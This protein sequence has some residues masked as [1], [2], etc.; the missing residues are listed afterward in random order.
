ME[1]LCWDEFAGAGEGR[2]RKEAEVGHVANEH[3]EWLDV[4]GLKADAHWTGGMLITSAKMRQ[5]HKTITKLGQLKSTVLIQGESGTGKELVAEA[6]HKL[7]PFST[8][9]FVVFN[10]SNLVD[11]LA[12][13]QLFGHVKGSFTDAR[14]DALGYFRSAEGGTLFLDEIGDLPLALQP[15]LLRAVETHEIQPVG[16]S[17]SY[18]VDFRLVVATNRDVRAM[19]AEGRFRD[20]LYYRLNAA[21]IMVPPLR[22]RREAIGA[23]IAHFIELYSGESG[24]EVKYISRRAL[25]LLMSY[26]WPGNLRELHHVIENVVVM[27]EGDR[28]DAGL[29]PSYIGAPGAKACGLDA[30]APGAQLWDQPGSAGNGDIVPA[31]H[32]LDDAIKTALVRALREAKGNCLVAAKLLGVSRYTVYRMMARYSVGQARDFRDESDE[33]RRN[34]VLLRSE[35]VRS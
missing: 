14:E 31:S 27:A 17:R 13:A 11:S 7:S 16:S 2:A 18:H 34:H 35:A 22:E 32:S 30:Q 25:S 23:F 3:A 12:E 20:D 1:F 15:K 33:W 29:L 24:R 4:S 10:C 5:L 9:P 6:L 26:E 28:I 21:S 8:G 19:V